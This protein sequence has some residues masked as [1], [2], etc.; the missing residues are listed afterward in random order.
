MSVQELS[1]LHRRY[2][3]LSQR[4]RAAWVFHQ[5]IQSLGRVNGGEAPPSP[6]ADRFQ[7]LY[8]QLKE[9]SQSLTPGESAPLTGRFDDIGAEIDELLTALLAE[10]SKVTPPALRQFF[11]KFRNY[12]EKI[13][14][15]LTRFYLFACAD[16]DWTA[17]RRDKVDFLVTRLGLE[18][19]RTDLGP[20]GGTSREREIF[21]SFWNL[22]GAPAPAEEKL[23]GLRRALEEIR[24]ELDGVAGLDQLTDSESLRNYREFKHNLGALFFH[25]DI[26]AAVLATNFAFRDTVR[27]LYQKEEQRIAADYQRIF[28]LEREV[29]VDIQLDQELTL[30]RQQ[31]ERFER[32]LQA[33]EMRLDDLVELR[34]RA[35]SLIPR[36]GG[37]EAGAGAAATAPD[38]ETTAVVAPEPEHLGDEEVSV[39]AA[40]QALI[41]DVEQRNG[42][43]EPPRLIQEPYRQLVEAL[44]E[45]TLGAPARSIILTPEVYPF[46][47][48]AREVVAYRRLHEG[49]MAGANHDLETERFLLEGAAL[50]VA[51]HGAVDATR[52]GLDATGGGGDAVRHARHLTSLGDAYLRRYDHLQEQALLDGTL[53]EARSLAVLRVR[54]M[55]D[56]AELWLLAHHDLRRAEG[57]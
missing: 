3:D 39:S 47:L 26:L 27:R 44:S 4:F 19:R 32:R 22:A 10:D 52:E 55:R 2:V 40:M 1:D 9:C 29:P 15:Q 16:S 56:Y 36:L 20:G 18:L 43:A 17:D 48:E 50:R 24:R 13:L 54:M 7:A 33:D 25:P 12:D 31:V 11:Q 46:R 6:H 57:G 37:G 14:A 21:E 45:T 34:E 42:G 38:E 30:F 41:D 23:A 5:F 35:R 51:L 28:D 8:G 53:D 49:A